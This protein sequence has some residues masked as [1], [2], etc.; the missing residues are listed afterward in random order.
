MEVNELHR[1]NDRDSI[2]LKDH[3]IFLAAI[4]CFWFSTYIYIPTFGIY[5]ETTGLSY[6]AIGIIL[7]SY[8]ISQVLLRLPLGL[9]S[10]SLEILKKWLLFIGMFLAFIS[11]LLLV[12]FDSFA[13]ILI[14]RILAGITASMW[15]I[16]TI[17][18]SDYF[19]KNRASQA[20]SVLQL[21][22]VAT[23]FLSMILCG[24]LIE[25]FG[26]DLPFWLGAVS[27]FIGCV[28]VLNIKV[29]QLD[30]VENRESISVTL[31]KTFGLKRLKM[32]T[33]LS[34]IAHAILFI[35][36]FGFSPLYAVHIGIKES[37]NIWLMS[38][39][40]IPH[41][42]ASL[43]LSFY[44]VDPKYNYKIMIYSFSV[45]AVS[46]FFIPFSNSL[47]TL[48]IIH[49]IIGLMLGLIFPILLG[50]V[51]I[52]SPSELKLAA[53]GFYQS[54]YAIGIF[55][56]PMIA[57]EIA[58]KTGLNEV[59]IF[60]SVLSIIAAGILLYIRMTGVGVAKKE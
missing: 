2:S 51:V 34:L 50:E 25:Y 33:F 9:L 48:G 35:T 40:F 19:K 23:Q 30:Q 21:V 54:F 46:L 17:L 39:F 8:G 58:E 1:D 42:L 6:A 27:A 22:T 11:G 3:M 20:M 41:I 38:A 47:L 45:A 16:A 18:Y 10:N 13:F 31:Q 55:I 29:V 37:A 60:T 56:G 5:L 57:G 24:L 12:Y 52:L 36:I 32:V 59:F 4:F 53:M 15:V 14:A 7:G 49:M 43:Y 44:K 28:L 26:W